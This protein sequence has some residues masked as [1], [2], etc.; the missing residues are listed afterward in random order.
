MALKVVY[1]Y[2]KRIRDVIVILFNII[3]T[4]YIFFL[5]L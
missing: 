5:T 1:P 2:G 4:I 3:F